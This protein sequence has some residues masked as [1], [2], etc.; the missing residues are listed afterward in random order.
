MILKGNVE[1]SVTQRKF[2]NGSDFSIVHFTI[3]MN[4]FAKAIGNIHDLE[5]G[6]CPETRE[7]ERI[8]WMTNSQTI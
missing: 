7:G 4:D 8:F 6:E 1:I 5:M 3:F 2:F